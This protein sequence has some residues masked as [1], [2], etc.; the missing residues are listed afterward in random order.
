[1]NAPWL[2]V[3]MPTWNGERYV[4][5]ALESV[6]RQGD[7][8]VEVIVVDDGSTDRT[9]EIVESFHE[10]LD[11][12]V[13]DLAHGGNWAANTNVGMQAARGDWI[14]WLHQDDLWSDDRLETLKTVVRERP[15]AS[16]VLHPSWYVDALGKR[17][18]RFGCPLPEGPRY[19]SSAL[20]RER[21][22]VQCFVATCAPLFRRE[23]MEEV[24][25]MDESLWYSADWDYWLKLASTGP[26]AYHPQPLASYRIHAESQSARRLPR[27]EDLRRQHDLMLARH[28]PTGVSD[29]CGRL[30]AGAARFS[31]DVNLA[32]AGVLNGEWAGL[33][34]LVVKMLK[35]GPFGIRRYLRDSRIVERA[36]S[37]L[38]AGAGDWPGVEELAMRGSC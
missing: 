38:R 24:G 13:I 15:Q 21:L 33:W 36:A 3:V 2:S 14:C 29:R 8:G 4:R 37:R 32:L 22:L 18:G 5:T 25:P 1:M 16:L 11:L 7:S 23:A 19:L 28:L 12:R 34:K 26:T 20:V 31:A 6:V 9:L 35:L 17:V 10:R 30:T 27:L